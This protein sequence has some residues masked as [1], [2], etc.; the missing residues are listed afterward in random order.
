[1]IYL[2]TRPIVWLIKIVKRVITAPFRALRARRDRRA[3]KDAKFAAQAIR[4]QQ[5]VAK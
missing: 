3:R 2:I 5:K 1:M 4:E